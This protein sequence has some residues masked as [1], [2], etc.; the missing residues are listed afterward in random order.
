MWGL[1]VTFKFWILCNGTIVEQWFRG[2]VMVS[3][4]VECCRLSRRLLNRNRGEGF[5]KCGHRKQ[6]T[7][8]SVI[9]FRPD[10]P[11]SPINDYFLNVLRVAWGILRNHPRRHF[12]GAVARIHKSPSLAVVAVG[13]FLSENHFE[14]QLGVKLTNKS[15]HQLKQIEIEQV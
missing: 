5:A 15:C 2:T 7:R 6:S 9:D 12:P 3:R 1:P 8:P 10:P 14:A 4:V 13:C 11:H